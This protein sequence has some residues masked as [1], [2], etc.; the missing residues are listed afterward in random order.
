M[1]TRGRATVLG[2]GALGL[3]AFLGL[4]VSAAEGVPP[5]QLAAMS[6]ALGGGCGLAALMMRGGHD[7]SG[8][9]SRPWAGLA[10]LIQPA[11]VWALGV[12]GLFGYHALYFA[13]LRA[14]PPAETGLIN[15]LWP[16]LIVLLSAPLAGETLTRRHVLGA[17]M[18]FAGVLVLVAG[19]G[20]LALS[21]AYGTGYLLALAAA[22]VWALYSVLSR[23]FGEVPSGAV[24]G[25]CLAS[26]AASLACHVAFET[27]VWPSGRQG[28]LAVA[29][30]G[31]GPVGAAFFLWD[32]GMKH[33]DIRLLGVLSYATPLASTLILV[34]GGYAEPSLALALSC[35][36]IAAGALL[37]TGV[38]RRAAAAEN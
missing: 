36:L 22:F 2:C 13:A 17:L 10:D 18:G 30:L 29:L 1:T 11:K 26:A 7:A 35:V 19:R 5:F 23:R 20:G 14:A 27:T 31:L 28:W 15:Y 3:W 21:S 38:T 6:F 37:A 24:A 25:F 34:L 33:G 32:V 16:L 12:G 4:L 9:S 8:R